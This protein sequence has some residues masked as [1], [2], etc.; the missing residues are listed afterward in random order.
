VAAARSDKAPDPLG[1]RAL[2]WVPSAGE[3]GSSEFGGTGLT[4]ALPVGKRALYSGAPPEPDSLAMTSGNPLSERGSI[5]VECARCGQTS[6]V[7]VLDLLI[8]QLPLGV[9]RPRRRFDHRMTCPACR[10]RAWC[11]FTLRRS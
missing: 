11:S 10:K 4:T 9:W 7:G 1:K 8:Y 2:F 6:H 5:T 3:S